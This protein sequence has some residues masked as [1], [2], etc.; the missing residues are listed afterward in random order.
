MGVQREYK[1]LFMFHKGKKL[2]HAEISFARDP[3]AVLRKH[4][5]GEVPATKDVFGRDHMGEDRAMLVWEIGYVNRSEAMAYLRAWKEKIQNGGYEW[6]GCVSL[7][8]NKGKELTGYEKYRIE[9]LSIEQLLNGA[10]GQVVRSEHAGE[11]RRSVFQKLSTTATNDLLRIRTNGATIN[12]FR[13]MCQDRGMTQ[14]QGFELLVGSCTGSVDS[15][16]SDWQKRLEKANEEINVRNSQIDELKEKLRRMEEG[17]EYPKKYRKAKLRGDLLREFFARL[18][19]PEYKPKQKLRIHS[20]CS[21]KMIFPGGAKYMYPENEGIILLTLEHAQYSQ[22]KPS[23]MFIL[24][25]DVENNRVRIRWYPQRKDVFGASIYQSPYFC[26]NAPWLFAV[27]KEGKAMEMI[28]GL[29]V[30]GSIE[31]ETDMVEFIQND[32]IVETVVRESKELDASY[33]DIA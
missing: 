8:N 20:S 32:K 19:E 31:E 7:D 2:V 6:I 22:S 11:S 12:R 21:G 30:L 26:A 17:K 25:R 1:I 14:N 13:Q 9:K 18:P 29:P 33:E 4:L 16:V 28:G 3:S 10:I 15:L 24:G 5:R 27:L 23:C